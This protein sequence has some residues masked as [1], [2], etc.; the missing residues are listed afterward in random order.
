[1]FSRFKKSPL[2][3]AAPAL[4]LLLGVIFLTS[5]CSDEPVSIGR[6]YFIRVYCY[7][8][9]YADVEPGNADY[10]RIIAEVERMLQKNEIRSRYKRDEELPESDMLN[11][12]SLFGLELYYHPEPVQFRFNKEKFVQRFYLDLAGSRLFGAASAGSPYSRGAY[13]L[14]PSV[15]L[16]EIAERIFREQ[17]GLPGS[18]NVEQV[19]E[20]I[21]SDGR[22]IPGERFRLREGSDLGKI[23]AAFNTLK[24]CP[25]PHQDE[26]PRVTITVFLK[27]GEFRVIQ[28]VSS[29]G[30]FRL[31]YSFYKAEAEIRIS[32]FIYATSETLTDI[33]SSYGEIF[34]QLRREE[35]TTWSSG[36]LK[37][38]PGSKYA[39]YPGPAPWFTMSH[40]GEIA[41]GTV[42]EVLE[43]V[44]VW[45][46]VKTGETEGWIPSWYLSDDTA[47]PVRTLST[48]YKVL[49]QTADGRL[50]PGGPVIV[51]LDKGR[52]LK[53][54][55]EW[56]DW[57]EIKLIAYDVPAVHT[58]WLPAGLLS[59]IGEAEAREG[60]LKRGTIFYDVSEFE[61]IS[62]AGAEQ[63][64][65]DMPV[66][67]MERREGFIFVSSVGGWN[68]WTREEN[69]TFE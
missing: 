45:A 5:A 14:E 46:R 38:R 4:F 21:V 55:K 35:E 42:V 10:E 68:A 41:G 7:S 1:M 49:N 67:V 62:A 12:M 8:P 16:P 50:Y 39:L 59:E 22:G 2:A 23:V 52:L 65:F 54:L 47:K 11:W 64:A 26:P 56:D 69:L 61:Q 43:G 37:V 34:A 57:I 28:D 36:P 31:S 29:S 48:G 44:G 63:I 66:V 58:A 40:G 19:E 25:P 53:P 51:E 32:G 33:Y 15:T 3:L 30:L 24:F 20:M 27:D 17:W 60:F 6:P 13:I 9:H 18:I